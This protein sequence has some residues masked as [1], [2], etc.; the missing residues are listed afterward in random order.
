M[1]AALEP[2]RDGFLELRRK[3]GRALV[4]AR[5]LP[6]IHDPHPRHFLVI[7]PFR[8][9]EQGVFSFATIEI[10]FERWRGR[11]EHDR[12]AFHLPAHDGNVARVV[13]RGFLLLVGVLM[14]LIDDDNTER[15]HGRKNCRA[16]ANDNARA[17]LT[18]LMPFIVA[19][20]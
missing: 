20:A 9:F 5:R 4:L 13:T 12:R 15:I 3:N 18:N 6:H 11:T 17:P 10:G 7:H 2:L 19:F 8:Q 1:F 14:L 16:G